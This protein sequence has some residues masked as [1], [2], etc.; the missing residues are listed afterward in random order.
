M[1]RKTAAWGRP[2]AQASTRLGR[3]PLAF[4][5]SLVLCL[6]LLPGA[7]LA[8]GEGSAAVSYGLW[9]GGEEITSENADSIFEDE[10]KAVVH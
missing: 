10:G 6:G 2:H 5:L 7:A 4:I 1:K 9:L 8:E 3:K